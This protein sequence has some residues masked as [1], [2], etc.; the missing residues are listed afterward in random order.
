[1]YTHDGRDPLGLVVWLYEPLLRAR[2]EQS[3][4]LVHVKTPSAAPHNASSA[5][6]VQHN[7]IESVPAKL[8]VPTTEEVAVKVRRTADDLQRDIACFVTVHDNATF[9]M[10]PRACKSVLGNFWHEFT[11]SS[12]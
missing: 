7:I 11:I 1:M 9:T 6:A 5:D 8:G 3:Y 12:D 2:R 10:R 4:T